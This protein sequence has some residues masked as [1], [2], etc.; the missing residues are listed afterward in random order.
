[1]N[2]EVVFNE[3]ETIKVTVYEASN[4]SCPIFK[5]ESDNKYSNVSE[6]ISDTLQM[7]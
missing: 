7:Y 1:M 4:C 6:I 5:I 2:N 3:V